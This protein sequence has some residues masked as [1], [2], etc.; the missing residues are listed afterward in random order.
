MQKKPGKSASLLIHIS[1][2]LLI[3]T[4]NPIFATGLRFFVLSLY[5]DKR[6]IFYKSHPYLDNTMQIIHSLIYML[7]EMAPYILLG[8]LIAGLLHAFVPDDTFARHLSGRGWKSVVKSR[9]YRCSIASLLMRSA[10]D[11]YCPPSRG[12]LPKPAQH[13]FS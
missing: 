7:C 2:C 4:R 10:T 3:I 9:R 8:F 6:N 5:C 12:A 1:S 11:S 13:L